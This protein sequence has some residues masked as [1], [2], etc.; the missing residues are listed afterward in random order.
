MPANRLV[1][2]ESVS[3]SY[4]ETS[5]PGARAGVWWWD[6]ETAVAWEV[7]QGNAFLGPGVLRV[8][9]GV[10]PR[11]DVLVLARVV[12]LAPASTNQVRLVVEAS[13]DLRH[14]QPAAEVWL[15]GPEE[16]RPLFVRVAPDKGHPDK[17][18]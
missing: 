3:W 15:P 18:Q 8:V 10:P 16:G 11:A 13:A 17:G 6:G 9:R 14:W 4:Q 5:Y 2:V 1:R 12:E 7:S